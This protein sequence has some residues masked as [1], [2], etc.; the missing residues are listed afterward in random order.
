MSLLESRARRAR[1]TT[2]EP[3]PRDGSLR[4]LPPTRRVR[5]HVRD[6][7]SVAGLSLAASLGVT[8]VVWALL[9]WLG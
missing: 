3:L 1:R 8:A 9:R 4:A 5:H 7:V 6:G 2:T